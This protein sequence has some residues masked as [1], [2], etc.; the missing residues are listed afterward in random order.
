MDAFLSEC[1]QCCDLFSTEREYLTV[2]KNIRI[3][4]LCYLLLD[5]YYF[6][7]IVSHEARGLN[8][9]RTLFESLEKVDL[10]L[11]IKTSEN[12]RKERILQRNI[13]THHDM[14]TFDNDLI[15]RADELFLTLGFIIIDNNHNIKQTLTQ[16]KE[17]IKNYGGKF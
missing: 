6:S 7:T 11:Q 9:D 1:V 14:N 15:R 8:V 5:R 10:K 2:F 3:I 16:T 12:K 13:Q 4:V 17:T